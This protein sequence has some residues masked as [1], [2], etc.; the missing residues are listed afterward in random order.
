MYPLLVS[1]LPIEQLLEAIH[2]STGTPLVRVP[3]HQDSV[4]R[5]AGD[6]LLAGETDNRSYLVDLGAAMFATMPS[7]LSKIASDSEC[8]IV[9]SNYDRMESQ[10]EF[11]AVQNDNI[12]RLYWHNAQRTIKDY[13]VGE[14]L[15]CESSVPLSAPNGAGLTAALRSFGFHQMDSAKGFQRASGDF[16]VTWAGDALEWHKQDALVLQISDLVRQNLNPTYR[17]PIPRVRIRPM[18]T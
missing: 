17:A 16:F 13:S 1:D 2:R 4:A 9:A 7:L 6:L 15:E 5:D 14:P 8:L 3:P 18:D 12:L 10:C 11:F